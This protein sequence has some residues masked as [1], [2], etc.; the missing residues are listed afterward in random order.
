MSEL[1]GVEIGGYSYSSDESSGI[2]DILINSYK[3]N[4]YNKSNTNY[5]LLRCK[6]GTN[7]SMNNII[8]DFH[9]HPE[10]KLGATFEA[11]EI[12]VDVLSKKAIQSGMPNAKFI[13]LFRIFGQEE[14]ETYDYTF[15]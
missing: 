12:S 5:Y 10:G 4:T 7:F 6:Y 2:T 14:P 11:P 8:E 13:I 1:A 9:T 15:E 3:R